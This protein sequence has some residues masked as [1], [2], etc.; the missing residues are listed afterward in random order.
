ML[1]VVSDAFQRVKMIMASFGVVFHV[2]CDDKSNG[3]L[4][5]FDTSFIMMTLVKS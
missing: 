1:V 4:D 5:E 3:V 2:F